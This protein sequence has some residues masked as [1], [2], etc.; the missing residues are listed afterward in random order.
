MY[1]VVFKDV[2]LYTILKQIDEVKQEIGTTFT[3][4]ILQMFYYK[5]Q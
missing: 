3:G 1:Y 2:K 4:T 5:I